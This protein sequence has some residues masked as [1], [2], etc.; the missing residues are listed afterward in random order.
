MV[1]PT[2]CK[3]NVA[4][5]LKFVYARF[6]FVFLLLKLRMSGL[7]IAFKV[8]LESFFSCSILF[9]WRSI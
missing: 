1:E 5:L 9:L 4:V 3:E 8:Y 7:S 6:G 2:S